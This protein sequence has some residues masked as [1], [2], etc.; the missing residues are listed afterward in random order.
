MLVQVFKHYQRVPSTGQLPKLAAKHPKLGCCCV[1]VLM[2]QYADVLRSWFGWENNG[3][4]T[5]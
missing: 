3:A 2:C 5:L 1:D 4:A